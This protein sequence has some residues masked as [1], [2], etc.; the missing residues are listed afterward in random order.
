[1]RRAYLKS[2]G[3]RWLGG[4]TAVVGLGSVELIRYTMNSQPF[5]KAILSNA[6]LLVVFT[7]L[8]LVSIYVLIRRPS[9]LG[10]V[11]YLIGAAAGP[12]ILWGLGSY[13]E[14]PSLA[15]ASLSIAVVVGFTPLPRAGTVD[16]RRAGDEHVTT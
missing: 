14:G 9:R 3:L 4:L 1:M 7:G 5:G 13:L 16:E 8:L 6:G 10:W 15:W 2:V 12:L 11:S